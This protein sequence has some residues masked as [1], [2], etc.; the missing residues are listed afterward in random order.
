M[1]IIVFILIFLWNSLSFAQDREGLSIGA[2]M[3]SGNSIY[4][5]VDNVLRVYPSIE[6]R[7]GPWE[8]GLANG[9]K[10]KVLDGKKIE[11]D[12][13]LSPSFGPYE[14]GDSSSLSGMN[15]DATA[16]FS[17][18]SKYQI[19]S[20]TNLNL[21][22]GMEVTREHDGTFVNLS[23]NQFIFPFLG[24]PVFADIGV[25][26]YD[27]KK[28]KY[29]YGVY[30]SEVISGRAAYSPGATMTPYLGINSFFPITER[31]SGFVRLNMDFLPSK[32]K[33]SP[34]VSESTS[35]LALFGVSTTF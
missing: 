14:S 2:I 9:I 8:L 6:Y 7:K 11:F 34:I 23:L 16:D 19:A 25:K 17:L 35:V 13:Q 28:S 15:R 18:G 26:R 10:Y 21:R 31:I 24:N 33:D 3:M 5:G 30:D 32:V 4:Q 22:A 12:V 27:A 20:G 1:R 29:L